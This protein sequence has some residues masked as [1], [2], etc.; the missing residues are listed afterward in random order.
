MLFSLFLVRH[1]DHLLGM[2]CFPP[3]EAEL[4][5]R[6]FYL[7]YGDGTEYFMFIAEAESFRDKMLAKGHAVDLSLGL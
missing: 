2:L 3:N 6:P 5:H 7:A 4:S 1:L